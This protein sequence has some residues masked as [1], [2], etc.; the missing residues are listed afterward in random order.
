MNN[1]AF[2]I[3]GGN[4]TNKGAQSMLLITIS[5]LRKRYKDCRIVILPLDDYRQYASR[6]LKNIIAISNH[7]DIHPADE[8]VVTA[9]FLTAKNILRFC[10]GKNNVISGLWKYRN[11]LRHV[12]AIVDIS[13]FCLS[14]QFCVDYNVQLLQTLEDGIRHNIP[15][16]L[17]PQSFGPFTYKQNC[18][19][20]VER[21]RKDL[22]AARVVFSR[23]KTGYDLL[24]KELGLKN[25][26]SSLDLVLQNKS[27]DM[28]V[29][30]E[31]KPE[32][33]IPKITT[34]D[35]VAVIPNSMNVTHS[36]LNVV[37][38]TYQNTITMLR[39]RNKTV[40]VMYHSNADRSLCDKIIQPF[41]DDTGVVFLDSDFACYQYDQIVRKMDYIIGSRYHSIVHAYKNAI[42]SII[43][44]WADK[45]YA[46]AAIFDQQE[47]VL[48][49]SGVIGTNWISNALDK[50]EHNKAKY[51][52]DIRSKLIEIQKDNCFQVLEEVIPEK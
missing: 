45:Y 34:H 16:V 39:N 30:F 11:T 37:I 31:K 35:N 1:K 43:F 25:V 52:Q 23:E 28:D 26:R 17:M 21:I 4:F 41:A 44:G 24:T 9:L 49:V 14:S 46:L 29:I 10:F 18:E 27:I 32:I 51:S 33:L 2:L 50:M 7:P 12:D 48:D 42:P 3:T 47:Y 36:D 6:G 13:G 22:S 20:M 5:E 19:E 15:I 38:W 8:S 40:Y